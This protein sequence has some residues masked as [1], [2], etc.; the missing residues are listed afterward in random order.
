MAKS[1][2]SCHLQIVKILLLPWELGCLL[3]LFVV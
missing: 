2:V 1:Y 3:F